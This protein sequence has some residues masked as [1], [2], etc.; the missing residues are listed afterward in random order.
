MIAA[1]GI[2][3]AGIYREKNGVWVA[4]KTNDFRFTRIL[5]SKDCGNA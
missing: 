3:K 2:E 1:T 4:A 5:N